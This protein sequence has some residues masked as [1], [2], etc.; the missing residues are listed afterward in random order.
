MAI[1]P[2]YQTTDGLTF[3]D[4]V[5]AEAHQAELDSAEAKKAALEQTRATALSDMAIAEES[6]LNMYNSFVS[7]YGVFTERS[8]NIKEALRKTVEEN[9][10]KG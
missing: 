8:N 7:T 2:I 1:T 10:K 6:L 5:S 3:T 4:Q 9:N